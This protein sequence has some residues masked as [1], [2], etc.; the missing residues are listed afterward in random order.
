MSFSRTKYEQLDGI[1]YDNGLNNIDI[2][3]SNSN[4]KV[5][6]NGVEP[7]AG[8]GGGV[9]PVGDIDFIGNLNCNDVAGGG[10]KGIITAEKKLS[11]GV[12]GI[13]TTGGVNIQTNGNLTLVG[14]GNI[15]QQGTGKIT[16]GSAG[17]ESKG[18]ITTIGAQDL[19]IGK[20]IYFDGQDIYHRTF[21]PSAQQN[22][23][24]FKQLPGKNDN[25]IYTGS[26]KFRS[27]AV[28][29][30]A[31]NTD[32]PAVYEDTIT[33][34]T[35]GNIQCET[36]NNVS[37]ITTGTIT[38]DNGGVNECKAKIFNTRTSGTNGWNI[39][40]AE[41]EAN[42]PG[43]AANNILQIAAT[44]AQ[45]VGELVE[46]YITSSEY[47]PTNNDNP[48]IKLIPDTVLN[49]GK[50]QAAQFDLGTAPSRYYLKQ[51]IGG[52]NDKVLQI[53]AP[54][55]NASV[56]FKDNANADVLV[57]KNTAVEL[58]NTIPISFGS[59]DFR[60]IQFY[61][62]ITAFSFNNSAL[63][64]TNQIFKTNDTDW[65]NK[66]TGATGQNLG[67]PVAANQGAY[68]LGFAQIGASTLGQ[69]NGLRFI[70]DTVLTQANDNLPNVILPSA[71]AYSF[72]AYDG[73]SAPIVTMSPGF[74]HYSVF[75]QF[76]GVSGSE[77]SNVRITLTKMPFFA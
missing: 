14:N 70:S 17:I 44:Q 3:T 33:L 71:S 19:I 26:N 7:S 54:T 66:N 49:G 37:S 18:D 68:K 27:S 22:Y 63:G 10:A 56:N 58:A 28:S 29:I 67:M 20:D 30:Q 47:D 46:V 13:E 6:I 61:K 43:K 48:N 50:V 23:K 60:P 73:T 51:D 12:G 24:D 69:I 38:C 15:N 5:L 72:E 21:N 42:P 39:K 4:T 45:A 76:P 55:T 1:I 32:V 25:N 36:I 16:S 34:N 8:G 41:E 35:N 52:P 57:I 40:Q 2:K 59:Y 31:L 75:A 53:K 62:D 11:S 64:S 77:T 74:L 65:I 9:P